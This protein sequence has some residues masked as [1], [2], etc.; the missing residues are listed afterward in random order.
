MKKIV[1]FG[2]S[3]KSNFN[4][5]KAVLE[6]LIEKGLEVHYFGFS[7]Y[8]EE[9]IGMGIKFYKYTGMNDI[10]RI[11]NMTDVDM[12]RDIDNLIMRC[13]IY[14]RR[15]LE[16]F[17][18]ISEH[19]LKKVIDINPD[20]V[21]RDYSAVNGKIIASKLGIKTVGVNSLITIPE[22][23]VKKNPVKYFGLYN[24]INIKELEG[25]ASKEFYKEIVKGH[26]NNSI[27]SNLP[28]L[29]PVHIVDG[30]DDVNIA[31]GGN[32]I[33]EERTY[34][35]RRY[36]AVKHPLKNMNSVSNNEIEEFLSCGKKIIYVSTGSMING[37]NIFYNKIISAIIGSDYNMI[38][39]I[40]NIKKNKVNLPN[41]V[42]VKSNVDQHR[43]LS[44]ADL[45]IN[46]GGYN[47]ICE[48]IEYKVP[49]FINPVVNDQAYNAYKV[50]ELGI[51]EILEIEKM[52]ISDI[53]N[54]IEYIVNNGKY[55][56]RLG[57]VRENFNGATKLDEVIDKII[58]EL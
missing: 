43:I 6:K 4:L 57:V 45:S 9:I 51:G 52:S 17:K 31:F 20:I 48:C 14:N 37:S 36:F 12:K 8:E 24:S 46:I 40:P 22:E 10:N 26:I 23:L 18:I 38:I 41:N 5:L 16:Y 15:L 42:M 7:E 35:S 33:Q 39:S 13:N 56:E 53:K 11:L 19:D 49:M 50:K 2:W 3:P 28:Y 29:N 44:Q 54:T 30:Q 34:K 21:F 55:K 25:Y 47:T 27:L 32:L 1:F 58:V